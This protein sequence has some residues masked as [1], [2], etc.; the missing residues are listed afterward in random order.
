MAN[1]MSTGT[2]IPPIFISYSSQY[3]YLTAK[4]C[5]LIE[6]HLGAGSV[7][8]DQT[9][10]RAG[11]RFSPEITRA[12]DGAKAVV[13]VWTQGSVASDWVYAEAVRAGTR[14]VTVRTAD[15]DLQSIPL[16]FSVF[17]TPLV[18]D[19][20]ALLDGI[21]RRL[22]GEAPVRSSAP[23]DEGFH[24]FLLD[25]K[26]EHLPAWA[27]DTRPASL[28]LAKHRLVPFDDFHGIKDDF[29]RWATGTPAHALGRTTLGRLVHAPAGVGKTRALI[30]IADVL[31]REHGWL[32]GFVPRNVRGVGHE[33]VSGS[34]LRRLI[35]G[36]RDAAGLMLIVDYAESRQDDVAWLLTRWCGVPKRVR[37]RRGLCCCRVAPA[38]GGASSCGHIRA[39]RNSRA[40]A[41]TRTTRSRFPKTST[42]E[43]GGSCSMP[44]LRHFARIAV[45]QPRGTASL[46]S[47]RPI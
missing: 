35:L 29:V 6:D 43:I 44:R 37:S 10:L 26:Q 11:D 5:A 23:P 8:W 1:A 15:L 13:V 19:T 28:L 17:H 14:I 30:E 21:R 40:S 22:S 32:T 38:Y 9:G 7:W 31:T 36:G 16:P 27:G 42:A 2:A 3:R 39:C 20:P 25:P 24:G 4:L 34:A 18:D 47:H 41:A 33:A 45:V 12:L 46:A